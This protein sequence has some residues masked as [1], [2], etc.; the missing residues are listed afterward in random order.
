MTAQAPR[1]LRADAARNVERIVAAAREVFTEKGAEGQL[2]DIARRAGV[3]PATLYRHFAGKEDLILAILRRRFTE[4]LEPAIRRAEADP[5]PWSAL[6]T[7]LETALAITAEERPIFSV[8]RNATAFFAITQEYFAFLWVTLRRAQDAGVVRADLTADD[9]PRLFTMIIGVQRL[10]SDFGEAI[11][12]AQ[13]EPA[14]RDGWRRYL[15]LL[16]DSLRPAAATS[17]PPLHTPPPGSPAT[18]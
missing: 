18:E 3:A 11:I 6:V 13:P 17:L 14:P 12:G 9:L 16:L 10:G 1:R 15:S 7:L 2:D 5:D 8:A 4:D